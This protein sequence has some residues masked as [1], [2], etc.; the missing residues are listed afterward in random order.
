VS[1]PRRLR[2]FVPHA[3]AL[4]TD[5][6]PHGDGLLALNFLRRLAERGHELDVAVQEVAIRDALPQNLR[7]HRL[8]GGGDLGPARRLR[9]A[10]RAAALYRR[11]ARVRAYD[12]IHQFNPVDVGLTTFFPLRSPPIV[13]GPHPAPWPPE[14]RPR[15][16]IAWAPYG[17]LRAALRRL[18]QRRATRILVFV[19]AGAGNVMSRSARERVVVV[20]PGLDLD[21]FRPALPGDRTGPPTVLFLAGLEPRKGVETLLDAFAEVARSQPDARLLLAGRGSLEQRIRS[22]IAREPL[23]GRVALLGQVDRE[24]VPAL[25]RSATILCLPS[26]GEPFGMSALE[27]MASSLPVV[28]T[29]TGGLAELV[30]DGSGRKV[31]PG[32]APALARALDDLLAAGP[33]EL[34]AMGARNRALAEKYTWDAAV[35]RLEQVYAEVIRA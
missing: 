18:E 23:A 35:D 21:A 17:V 9:Y 2:L 32:D 15:R 4:L 8:M 1:P 33:D 6:E 22:R 7:L 11:L 27:A 31:P 19:P 24:A 12:L 28:A 5:H 20:P 3:S 30:P 25:V 13:L 26:F 14:E 34:A 10:L 16:G 29:A